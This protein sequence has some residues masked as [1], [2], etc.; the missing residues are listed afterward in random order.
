MPQNTCKPENLLFNITQ[1]K[2][3]PFTRLGI[4]SFS[5]VSFPLS[6]DN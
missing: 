6:L 4:I 2:S 3:D 1:I 5:Q